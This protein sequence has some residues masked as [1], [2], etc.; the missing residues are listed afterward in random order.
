LHDIGKFTLPETLLSKPDPLSP[1]E[2]QV[3]R[4][5]PEFGYEVLRNIPALSACAQGV[6]AQLEHYDGTGTPLG[7]R[8][9]HIPLPA[10]IIAVA[11][12]YDVM[13][14]PRGYAS[15]QSSVEALQ[16][17]EAC[18]AT[19][20]DPAIVLDLLAHFGLEPRLEEEWPLE[21]ES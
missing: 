8:S 3:V 10:R 9:E 20:F 16:E 14:H 11:N 17:I 18:A 7:I 15:E 6:L 5:H 21:T 13:T 2:I 1:D 4:R 19:Q 12:A